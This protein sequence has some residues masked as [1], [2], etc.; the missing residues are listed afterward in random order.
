MKNASGTPLLVQENQAIKRQKLD[1]GRSRQ[2]TFTPVL[3]YQLDCDSVYPNSFPLCPLKKQILNPKPHALP[4]K[5]KLGHTSSSA[6]VKKEDRKVYVREPASPFV[7]MAEMMKR[8]Q[9]STRD[10]SLPHISNVKHLSPSGP[11]SSFS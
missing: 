4:H 7:S 3:L 1:E 11:L 6:A 9:S 2:V 8:F 5:S 10:L